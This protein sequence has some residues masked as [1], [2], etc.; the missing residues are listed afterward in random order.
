MQNKYIEINV[1]EQEQ[2]RNYVLQNYDEVSPFI[3]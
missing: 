2:A 3:E 1:V